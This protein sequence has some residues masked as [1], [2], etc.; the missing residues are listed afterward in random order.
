MPLREIPREAWTA[1]FNGFS[2]EHE[3]WLSTVERID[4]ELGAQ[5]VSREKALR[6]V[7]A[8]PAADSITIFLGAG[9]GDHVAHTV[10]HA[11]RV[12]LRETDRG[13]HE[14][15]QIESRDGEDAVLRFRSLVLPESL[16]GYLAHE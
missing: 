1:F 3:R 6:G 4:A 11:T 9:R 13:A 5:V 12:W 10:R 2:R 14:S 16:D 15:L 7:S 8:D